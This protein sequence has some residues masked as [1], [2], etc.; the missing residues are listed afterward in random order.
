MIDELINTALDQAGNS[1]ER[2][3]VSLAEKV[4]QMISERNE[5]ARQIFDLESELRR[6][7]DCNEAAHESRIALKEDFDLTDL[8]I[9]RINALQG[10]AARAKATH[11]LEECR[12]IR[13]ASRK[14]LVKQPFSLLYA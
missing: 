4:D 10:K 2:E 6:F 14:Q 9:K 8:T 7:Y 3:L 12:D 13:D 1:E 11:L 5:Y